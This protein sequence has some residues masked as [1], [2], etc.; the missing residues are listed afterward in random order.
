MQRPTQDCHQSQPTLHSITFSGLPY[1]QSIIEG[2][3]QMAELQRRL[4]VDLEWEQHILGP[5]TTNKVY[6]PIALH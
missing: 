5:V 1:H 2:L 4:T 3:L 6:T